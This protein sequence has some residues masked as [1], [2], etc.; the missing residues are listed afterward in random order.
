LTGSPI[1]KP[2]MQNFYVAG[3]ILFC[4]AKKAYK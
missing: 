2:T 3:R 1:S 4:L